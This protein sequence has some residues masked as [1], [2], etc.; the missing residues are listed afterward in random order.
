MDTKK[1]VLL[2]G[3]A[4]T[5]GGILRREWGDRYELRLSDIRPVAN[6]GK[7]EQFVRVD[8]TELDQMQDACE[9]MDTIVHLAATPNPNAQFYDTLLPLNITGAYNAFEAAAM[10]GCRR[11][12]FASSLNAVKGYGGENPTVW[13]A[14]I[15]PVNVY[16]ATK[17]WGEALARVYSDQRELSCICVR[18]GSPRF[19][20]NGEWEPA[21]PNL[22]I[23][24]R[25]TAQ[26][27][28]RCVDVENVPFGIVHGMSRH[29]RSWLD[30]DHTSRLVGYEP[31]DGTAFPKAERGEGEIR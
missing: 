15:F 23:S 26:L 2:T 12:V 21:K 18:L 19:D 7:H 17:C 31:Q 11:L 28:G 29:Q 6:L 5:V 1:K 14:P 27:F 3:A 8:I 30:L 20:Q 22:G 13:E 4:G 16:G 9:G 10:A 25:D 24:P